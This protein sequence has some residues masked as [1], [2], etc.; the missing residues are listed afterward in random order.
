MTL[1]YAIGVVERQARNT[2]LRLTPSQI[3]KAAQMLQN[4]E[5]TRVL[6]TVAGLSKT[7]SPQY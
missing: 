6:V 3:V 5:K 2:G 7:K 1:D 4:A